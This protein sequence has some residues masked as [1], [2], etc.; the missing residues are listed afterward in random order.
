MNTKGALAIAAV[1]FGL[2]ACTTLGTNVSG[3]FRCEAADGICA[4]SLVIDD[5]AIARIEETI[6]VDLL[7]PAGPFRMDDGISAPV[8]GQ[9]LGSEALVA[10]SSPSYE[11]SVVFPGY[12]DA[13]GTAHARIAVPVK[14]ML[15]GR[16]DALETI[17]LRGAKPARAQGLLAAA[18]SAPQFMAIAPGILDDGQP[19]SVGAE[20]AMASNLP[21]TPA[22]IQQAPAQQA[23][24]QPSNPI[25]E[26]EAKVSERLA[27]QQ[28]LPRREAASFPAT[29]E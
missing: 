9:S 24:S 21:K 2:S 20:T 28:R 4:P 3:K 27:S 23:A 26:I 25:A 8:R 13:A 16:G 29:P 14:A 5:S 7:N 18:E 6:S 10:R 22:P 19:G 17:A 1:T 12:T 11:L 15:P